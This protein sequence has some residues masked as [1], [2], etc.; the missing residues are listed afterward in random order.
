MDTPNNQPG[1]QTPPTSSSAPAG[2]PSRPTQAEA[3]GSALKDLEN[4]FDTYLH[5]KAPYQLPPSSKEAIVKASPWITLI[6]MVVALPMV[7]SLIGLQAALSPFMTYYGAH[8]YFGGAYLLYELLVL[9]S[10][11]LEAVAIP[12]L[13]KRTQQAWHLVYYAA[14][15]S[16]L[17]QLLTG[18]IV[19]LIISLVLAMYFLFQVREYYK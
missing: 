2:S 13:F 10:F 3:G 5:K 12:G 1:A 18:N 8:Y 6:V 7:L 4:F 11:V 14:L 16:A 9:V 15:V 19:G 17:S